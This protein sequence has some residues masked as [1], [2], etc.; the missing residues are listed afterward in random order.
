MSS[1]CPVCEKDTLIVVSRVSGQAF[2]ACCNQKCKNEAVLMFDVG[3]D[4]NPSFVGFHEMVDA[5]NSMKETGL[6]RE[7]EP[8]F[9][10]DGTYE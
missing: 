6:S 1:I 10:G 5:L 7:D 3:F 8:M 9:L 4:G 2:Y